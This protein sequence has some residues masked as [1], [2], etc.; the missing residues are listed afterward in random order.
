[1]E[2][3]LYAAVILREVIVEGGLE[4]LNVSS[5]SGNCP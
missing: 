1:M 5:S 2:G 4:P 3:R